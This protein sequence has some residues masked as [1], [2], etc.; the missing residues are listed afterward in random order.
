MDHNNIIEFF[1]NL[2]MLKYLPQIGNDAGFGIIFVLG[3]LTSI[4]CLGMCGGIAISQTIKSSDGGDAANARQKRNDRTDDISEKTGKHFWII[5]SALYNLG[6]V[7]GYTTVGGIIGGLGKVI[8]FTG[9]LKGLVPLV[10]GI[11][12]VIMGINLLNIFPFLRKF[13]I[14]MPYFIARKLTGRHNLGPF[15]VGVLTALM[16]CGP[17]QIVQLYAM[18][19]GSVISGALAMLVFSLGTL[20]LLFLFGA[21]NSLINKNHTNVILKFSAAIV[22]VLGFVMVGRGLSLSG[23][24]VNLPILTSSNSVVDEGYAKIDGN[25]QTVTTSIKSGSFPEITVQKGI[26]VKW[27]IEVSEEDLNGC[28]SAITIPKLKLDVKF[29]V[30]DNIVEFTPDDKAEEIPYTCWMGMIKS[31]INVVDDLEQVVRK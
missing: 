16:P 14:R 17:L 5:P 7:I 8:G 29:N 10:G 28:N 4:H 9:I 3:L 22:I 1:K 27:T 26:P 31:R 20:P 2:F 21:V 12:M 13:N 15:A 6:R 18:G 19:T 30:G 23:Y 24:P 25:I 11:F